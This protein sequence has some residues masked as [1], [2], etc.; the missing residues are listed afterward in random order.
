MRV[1][2][3]GAGPAGLTAA[4]ILA[5]KGHEVDVYDLRPFGVWKP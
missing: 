1:G 2:V 3:I 4:K 5:E